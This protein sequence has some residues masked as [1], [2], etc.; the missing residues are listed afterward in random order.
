MSRWGL[1]SVAWLACVGA[2]GLDTSGEGLF[3]DDGGWSGDGGASGSGSASGGSS[4][5][6]SSSGGSSGSTSSSGGGKE[7]GVTDGGGEAAAPACVSGWTLVLGEMDTKACPAGYTDAYKGLANPQA[8]PGACTCSCNITTQPTCSVG[9]ITWNYGMTAPM[10]PGASPMY[11]N[12]KCTLILGSP[13]LGTAQQVQPL[14]LSGG[15]CSGQAVGSPS[16]VQETQVQTCSVPAANEASVCAG[17]APMGFSA[18]II[19]PGDV[20]CPSG[21]PF[22]KRTL[23]ADSEM[24]VCSA[25]GI[26]NVTGMC[27]NPTLTIYSDGFCQTKVAT[28]PANGMCVG[29][30][31]NATAGGF[32]Y[33]AQVQGAQ[34]SASGTS[35]SFQPTNPQ[36]LCCR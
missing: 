21:S 30:P 22:S 9:D 34:C 1:V 16:M 28:I 29:A 11:S 10:C 23:V 20:Q 32:W 14:P 27:Q 6:A 26:C 24:L 25:C 36:T 2:C 8:M 12:G 15:V 33:Q 5:S 13:A 3:S 31:M 19:A 35:A 17:T 7:G 18:C 4:G